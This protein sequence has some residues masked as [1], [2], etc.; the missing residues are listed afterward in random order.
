MASER[1]EAPQDD[2]ETYDSL[3]SLREAHARL[4]WTRQQAKKQAKGAAAASAANEAGTAGAEEIRKFLERAQAAGAFISEEEERHRAQSI[5]DYW[6]AEYLSTAESFDADFTPARL[7]DFDDDRGDAAQRSQRPE[8]QIKQRRREES[9]ELVQLAAAARQWKQWNRD[10]G[11][12]LSGDSLKQAALL[13]HCDP[14]LEEFV[15]ASEAAEAAWK[16]RKRVLVWS[17]FGIGATAVVVFGIVVFMHFIGFPSL[18]EREIAW[19]KN[20]ASQAKPGSQATSLKRLAFY[21]LWMTPTKSSFDLSSAGLEDVKL[22]KLRLYVP[23]F[24]QANVRNVEFQEAE[25]AYASFSDSRIDNLTFDQAALQFAQF[26]EAK[27]ASA[28]FA[29]ATLYRATFDR[30]CLGD[31]KFSG[32]DLRATSFWAVQFDGQLQGQF[33]NTAWWLAIG[34]SS[35]QLRKLLPLVPLPQ[36][37]ALQALR[38]SRAFKDQAVVQGHG[39][40]HVRPSTRPERQGM[41]ARDLG[42]RRC[43]RPYAVGRGCE[44]QCGLRRRGFET[45]RHTGKRSRCSRTSGVYRPNPE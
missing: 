11:L 7:A 25:F 8:A 5:L 30:A 28:S 2:N 23:N 22:R 1:A 39:C 43:Q 41:D 42:C 17:G 4:I 21:Q 40:R 20:P 35:E 34:W 13:R 9:R 10:P 29:G 31:V 36:S 26:R 15:T 37:K 45:D 44:E 14:D 19:I 38:D 3:T 33:E 18:S 32:A 24:S 12:L 27:I 6:T 16:T